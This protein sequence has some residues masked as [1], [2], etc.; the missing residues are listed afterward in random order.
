MSRYIPVIFSIIILS[1]CHSPNAELQKM[2]KQIDSLQTLVDDQYVPGFG[3]FMGRI[4]LH[5]ANLWFAGNEQNWELAQF[6]VHEI[7]E[8]IEDIEEFKKGRE[9]L[10]SMPMIKQPLEQVEKSIENKDLETFKASYLTLTNTCNACHA[11]TGNSQLVIKI[12]TM[13][14]LTNLEY[15]TEKTK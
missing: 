8:S 4:Q 2:Q 3:D 9:E 15:K 14:P 10:K 13:P 7:E 11:A 5:H 12:P 1:A 6:Q